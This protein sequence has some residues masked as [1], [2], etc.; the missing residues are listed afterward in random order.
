LQLSFLSIALFGDVHGGRGG[1]ETVS[2][3][4]VPDGE[5]ERIDIAATGQWWWNLRQALSWGGVKEMIS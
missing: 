2:I 1:V 4:A 3:R 5:C